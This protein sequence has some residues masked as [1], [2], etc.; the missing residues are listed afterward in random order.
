MNAASYASLAIAAIVFIVAIILRLASTTLG[1]LDGISNFTLLQTTVIF[2]LFS[3]CF[4]V[5]GKRH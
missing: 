1:I 3:I 2:L 5:L 4:A